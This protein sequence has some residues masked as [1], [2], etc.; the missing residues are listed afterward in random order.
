MLFNLFD[1]TGQAGL[2][3]QTEG[4]LSA[5]FFIFGSG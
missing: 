3:R 4:G 5:G 1:L 2:I